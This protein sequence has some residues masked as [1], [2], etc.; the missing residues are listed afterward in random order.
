[1]Q[2]TE[3]AVLVPHDQALR[4]LATFSAARRGEVGRS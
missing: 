1:M 4:R 2:G 3:A